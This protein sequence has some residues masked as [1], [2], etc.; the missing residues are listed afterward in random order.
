MISP[1]LHFALFIAFQTIFLKLLDLQKAV[2]KTSAG[3]WFQS[4][5]LLFT[6]EYFPMSVFCF[7]LLI[8]LSWLSLLRQHGLR[9]LSPIAFQA[10]S[11]LYVLKRAHMRAIFLRCVKVSQAN[12]FYDVQI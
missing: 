1:H 6:K 3:S 7:L 12:N 2:P 8:F 5:M 9:K 11:P 4:W 10:R